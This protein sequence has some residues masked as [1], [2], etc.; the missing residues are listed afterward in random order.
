MSGVFFL[1]GL[2][3]ALP[4]ALG[5]VS[6]SAPLAVAGVALGRHL[7]RDP[8]RRSVGAQPDLP[9]GRLPLRRA[10]HRPHRLRALDG[11]ARLRPA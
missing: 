2:P 3:G 10:G 8:G 11:A 7:L 9:R 1:L 4:L 6:G 5:V